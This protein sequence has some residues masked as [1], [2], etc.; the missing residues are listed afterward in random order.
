V[1]GRKKK[2]KCMEARVLNKGSGEEYHGV[3]GEEAGHRNGRSRPTFDEKRATRERTGAP[4]ENTE[5]SFHRQARVH[6][7]RAY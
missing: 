5:L 4:V 3:R 2:K 7:H 1:V 6:I